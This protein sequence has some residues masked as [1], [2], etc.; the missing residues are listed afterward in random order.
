MR[1]REQAGQVPPSFSLTL[2]VLLQEYSICLLV[3]RSFQTSLVPYKK[4]R[5]QE[6]KREKARERDNGT[7]KNI[8]QH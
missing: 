5:E 3:T 2:P 4:E 6:K 7:F 1:E 8:S